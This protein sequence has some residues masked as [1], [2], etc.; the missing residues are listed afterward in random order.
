LTQDANELTFHAKGVFLGMQ[1]RA[2]FLA[3]VIQFAAQQGAS[4]VQL[5]ALT[6]H[7]LAELNTDELFFPAG[8]YNAVVEQA[9]EQSGDSLL[10]LHLGD[11]LSLSAAGLI[12]QIVQS[13]RT[14]H[15]G[16]NYLVEYA[17]LGCQAMPFQ[18]IE[19]ADEWELAVEPHPVWLQQSPIAVRHTMDG[20]MVFTLRE[21]HS[22]TRQRFNPRRI[23]F[24]YSRPRQNLE[25]ERIFQC[26]IRFDQPR[27]ALFLEKKHLQEP[28]ITS[29]Y[30]L[31]SILIQYAQEK[32]EKLPQQ[33]S[34]SFAKIV[35]DSIINLVKPEFP[36]I[37]RVAASLNLSV[38]SLQRK[39]KA[40]GLTYK[41]LLD[42]LK[43]QFA[44]DYLRNPALSIKEI[45]YLLDYAEPS[46]FIRTFKRWTGKSPAEYRNPS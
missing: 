8:I 4:P 33:G 17:N 25:Y 9:V 20:S 13:S 44:L 27:T 35:Q 39:L 3:Q 5:S 6:G 34:T 23:H 1:F 38:R 22:L 28:V 45:A 19:H 36:T 46:S 18:L 41:G 2:R 30:R 26:P 31:L 37:Q 12:V 11:Y 32:L 29:D 21:F 43:Q 10:G 42:E 40:E 15:E 16:I 24:A 7:S 14:V